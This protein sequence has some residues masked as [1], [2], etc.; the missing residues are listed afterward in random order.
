[1]SST[2]NDKV[3]EKHLVN[4]EMLVGAVL[5]VYDAL[6]RSGIRVW[7]D[8]GWGIDALLEEQSRPHGD[9]DIAVSHDDV[10]GVCTELA[11]AGF[12]EQEGAD[13]RPYNF[14]LDDGAGHQVDVHTF[15]FDVQGNN[16]YG[17]AYPKESLTG[18]GVIG[19]QQVNC[20]ALEWV[21]RF[22]EQYVPDEADVADMKRLEERFGMAMPANYPSDG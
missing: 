13:A 15:L 22:H 7:I 21:I 4:N 6:C 16:S 17:I 9:L 18:H 14:V 12:V 11:K 20:I 5:A 3:P 10:D 1:M 2:N 8:G 19:G